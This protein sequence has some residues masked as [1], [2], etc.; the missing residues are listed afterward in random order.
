MQASIA[1]LDE[2]QQIVMP[3][4]R[5]SLDTIWIHCVDDN[6]SDGHVDSVLVQYPLVDGDDEVVTPGMSVPDVL[7][8]RD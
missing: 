8:T 2:E 3:P 5:P 7:E 1:S 4:S 6:S